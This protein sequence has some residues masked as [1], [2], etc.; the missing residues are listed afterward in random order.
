MFS[1]LQE[2]IMGPVFLPSGQ[3]QPLP[4]GSNILNKYGTR[5]TKKQKFW[6]LFRRI[7]IIFE[8]LSPINRYNPLKNKS[9]APQIALKC[10]EVEAIQVNKNLLVFTILLLSKETISISMN[11]FITK[12]HVA[13][14]Q[15]CVAWALKKWLARDRE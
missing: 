7:T 4:Q 9:L 2:V 12:A 15:K 14:N 10:Y 5:V 11:T 1:S 3:R 8:R 6:L 13:P